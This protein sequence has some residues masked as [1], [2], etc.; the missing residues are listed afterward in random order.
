MTLFLPLLGHGDLDLA[1]L[2]LVSLTLARSVN[3]DKVLRPTYPIIKNIFHVSLMQLDCCVETKTFTS[4]Y[5]FS[6]SVRGGRYI[7]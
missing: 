6:F 2:Q 1:R 4:L 5:Q 3:D 7:R